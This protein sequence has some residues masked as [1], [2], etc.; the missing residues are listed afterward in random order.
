MRRF[1]RASSGAA[2]FV[3]ALLLSLPGVRV[4]RAEAP[5]AQSEADAP[6]C[7]AASG[8]SASLQLQ[9]MRAQLAARAQEGSDASDFVSLRTTGHG[10]RAVN[11]ADLQPI[12]RELR[13]SRTR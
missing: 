13:I 2:L 5:P 3:L 4:V 11:R 9:R 7:R 10:Y 6:M 12:E 8:P 1:L